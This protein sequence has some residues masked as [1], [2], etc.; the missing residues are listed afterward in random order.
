MDYPRQ[1]PETREFFF[2]AF[3]R[4]VVP[5][6]GQEKRDRGSHGESKPGDGAEGQAR[7]AGSATYPATTAWDIVF[8]NRRYRGLH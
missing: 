2:S 5:A 7:K 3:P 6:I 8:T 1:H 4:G